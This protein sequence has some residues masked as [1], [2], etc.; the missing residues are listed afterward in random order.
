LLHV[1]IKSI[2]LLSLILSLQGVY[3]EEIRQYYSPGIDCSH[4]EN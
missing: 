3:H 2:V 1:L 4:A